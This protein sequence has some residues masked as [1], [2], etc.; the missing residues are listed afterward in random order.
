[1]GTMNAAQGIVVPVAERAVQ[2]MCVAIA[3]EVTAAKFK[4]PEGAAENE[5]RHG[6]VIVVAPPVVIVTCW[7]HG[8]ARAVVGIGIDTQACAV[9]VVAHVARIPHAPTDE[10]GDGG[11]CVEISRA[12]DAPVDGI[13]RNERISCDRVHAKVIASVDDIKTE[14]PGRA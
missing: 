9:A 11:R 12:D 3:V 10:K 5:T 14:G 8:I 7:P 13:D 4:A 1:M 6:R 2:V